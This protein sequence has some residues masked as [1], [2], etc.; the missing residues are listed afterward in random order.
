MSPRPCERVPP[1]TASIGRCFVLC[2]TSLA[3]ASLAF[4]LEAIAILLKID[5]VDFCRSFL[6]ARMG[7]ASTPK[8]GGLSVPPTGI[9][10]ATFGT[11]NQRSIP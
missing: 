10:P 6:A 7:E 4:E 3:T 1:K 2:R 11:G 8:G 5:P 9:E